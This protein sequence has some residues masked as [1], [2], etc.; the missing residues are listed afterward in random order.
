MITILIVTFLIVG[1][2]LAASIALGRSA[3]EV[4]SARDTEYL[5]LEGNWVRYNVIGGGPP[6]VLVHGWLSSSRVWDGLA[7]RLAQRFTVYTLDLTGFGESDKPL[8]GYG[9]RYGSRLL[10]AFC[11]HFGLTRTSVIGHDVGGDMA[12]KLAA[13]HPDVVG[14]LVLVATPANEEQIDLPT[15]LW[16]ATLPVLGPL[17]YALG[18]WVR[19]VRRMW[20]KPF[21]VHPEDLT[22]DA[23]EDAAMSTP[24]AASQTLSITRREI[25]GGRLARQARI[26]KVPVLL[27]AGEEDQIVDPQA[28]GV[29][30][31]GIS[32]AE[33]VLMDECGHLPMIERTSEFNAQILAFLTGDAR[34]LDYAEEAPVADDEALEHD[35]RDEYEEPDGEPDGEPGDE[36]AWEEVEL[37]TQAPARETFERDNEFEPDYEDRT[38]HSEPVAEPVVDEEPVR[39]DD[40]RASDT[41]TVHR[42]RGGSYRAASEPGAGRDTGRD[43][44]AD[45]S[46]NGIEENR[47]PRRGSRQDYRDIFERETGTGEST[48]KGEIPEVPEDLF[49]WP[50]S[51][52]EPR[53]R[54][55]SRDSDGPENQEPPPER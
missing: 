15:P 48:E 38:I 39:G 46:G 25:A 22:E 6:V 52:R 34:Y 21:V 32:Q 11:A 20:L 9:V 40:G 45:S 50:T 54:D 55:R 37:G 13:D 19:G 8:S 41:P 14:R 23:I 36:P 12:V 28:V 17:F 5:D 2:V 44:S 53:P 24:A 27:V 16:L 4:D 1:L 7:G 31:R 43:V 26:I 49:S 47:R 10:Y 51:R 30:A 29:W 18:R 33:V 3:Y 42:K 35:E